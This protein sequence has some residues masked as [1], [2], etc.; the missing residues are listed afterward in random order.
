MDDLLT[1]GVLFIF[2]LILFLIV[3]KGTQNDIN[4]LKRELEQERRKKKLQDLNWKK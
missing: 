1:L 2:V 4:S 3:S